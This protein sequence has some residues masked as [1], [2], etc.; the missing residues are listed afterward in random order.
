MDLDLSDD[1]IISLADNG[2]TEGAGF[3]SA[4]LEVKAAIKGKAI[5]FCK[6]ELKAS[7]AKRKTMGVIHSIAAKA[8]KG[9]Q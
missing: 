4:T 5:G 8:K 3:A 6:G 9:K 7:I 2:F 1:E